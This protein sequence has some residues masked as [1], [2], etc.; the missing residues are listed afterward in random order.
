MLA[1][2]L[3]ACRQLVWQTT[4]DHAMEDATNDCSLEQNAADA[5]VNEVAREHL[6]QHWTDK[7]D[8]IIESLQ[9]VGSDEWVQQ[10]VDNKMAAYAER[11]ELDHAEAAQ[12]RDAY[13][14]IWRE[15]ASELSARIADEDWDGLV[16]QARAI[17]EQEDASIAELLTSEQLDTYRA[18]EERSRVTIL[19]IFATLGEVSWED[20]A[21][22]P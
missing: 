2:E 3:T 12:L 21:L 6:R 5:I 22:V 13:E 1:G 17:W 19:A 8:D 11:L 4:A 18:G 9:D 7:R 15:H 20:E 16:D 14:A 10:E